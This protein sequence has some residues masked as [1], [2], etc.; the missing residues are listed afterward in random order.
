[1]SAKNFTSHKKQVR[2]R[3]P[4]ARCYMSKLSGMFFVKSLHRILAYEPSA[5]AAW[6]QANVNPKSIQ[7]PRP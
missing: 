1:M 3:W 7:S 5:N 2:Y 6:K 4:T